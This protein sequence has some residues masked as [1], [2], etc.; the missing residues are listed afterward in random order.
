M[1]KAAHGH[2]AFYPRWLQETM[3]LFA[4]ESRG[5]LWMHVCICNHFSKPSLPNCTKTSSPLDSKREL[6]LSTC[7]EARG[8]ERSHIK[9]IPAC[10]YSWTCF[11]TINI[12]SANCQLPVGKKLIWIRHKLASISIKLNS[13]LASKFMLAVG[14][15]QYLI[16]FP[17]QKCLLVHCW[18]RFKLAQQLSNKI[19]FNFCFLAHGCVISDMV[20]D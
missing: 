9:R 1:L 8:A 5:L 4:K 13:F 7:L 16:L 6:T 20:Q 14:A 10:K 17:R 11:T 18:N 19:W 15:R 12:L 2:V 3:I